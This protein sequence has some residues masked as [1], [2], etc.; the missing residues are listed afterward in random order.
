MLRNRHQWL[1]LFPLAGIL[2]GLY[3]FTYSGR[4]ESGDTLTLFNAT[5]SLVDYGDVLLDKS[6]AD[7]PPPPELPLSLYPLASVDVEP[8]QLILSAPLYWLASH[9]SHVGLVHAVWFFN[10]LVC[11]A[12]ALVFYVYAMQLGYRQGVAVLAAL[13]LGVGTIIW[14]YSKTFFREPLAGLFILLSALC[15][16]MLRARRYRSVVLFLVSAVLLTLALLTKEAVVFALPALLAVLF[17]SLPVPKRVWQ[18]AAAAVAAGVV[19]LLG[20]SVVGGSGALVP[21]YE[22]LAVLLRRTP[23]QVATMHQAFHSYVFSIG[24]S[25]WGT[26]PILLLGIPGLILFYRKQYY[27]Y[28]LVILLGLLGFAAGYAVLRGDHWFGGLSWPPR[29]LVPVVPL[30]MISILPALDQMLSSSRRAWWLL[31]SVFVGTWS[32]WIQ[33]TAVSVDWGTY[34]NLLPAEANGLLEWGGGLNV[35][36]YLRWIL[37][38]RVWGTI[39]LDFA[40]VRVNVPLWPLV[41]VIVIAVSGLWLIVFLRR[42]GGHGGKSSMADWGRAALFTSVVVILL[43]IGLVSINKDVIYSGGNAS[44]RSVLD[45]LASHM[46][47]DDVLLLADDEY[48]SFFLNS[49]KLPLPRVISLPDAPGEQPSETQ[50]ALVQSTNPDALLVKS[51]VP[52]IHNL[53][54]TRSRI[55]LLADFGSWHSWAV[56]PVERMMVMR[57]YPLQELTTDPPD[58]RVRL[59]EFSTVPAPD[60]FA[61][62]GPENLSDLRFGDAISLMGYSLPRGT[63]YRAGT[64]LPIS[65][66]WQADRA[67]EHNYTVAL[68]VADR[69]GKVVAQGADSQPAW[70][71]DPTSQWQPFIPVWDNRALRLPTDI[72]SG[73]YQI[74]LRLYQSDNSA[75][76]LPV[77]GDS[78]RDTSLAILPSEIQ[79]ES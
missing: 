24:G 22:T 61:F 70:G 9:I 27:R 60:P 11:T 72:T 23:Q 19:L 69:E 2:M 79:I 50:P 45:V 74:W 29:F 25:V 33:I 20:L 35:V 65:F 73:N 51:S 76:A 14:P 49:G 8:L 53:A 37:I 18:V 26:S 38:P 78:V 58:P 15:L 34:I 62:R 68:F 30:L 13:A 41:C 46:S 36:H 16:E 75:L 59:I 54:Q 40:W 5:A 47:T 1:I 42:Q 6:A 48:K 71:F 32:I 44:L 56:R 55:W 64:V 31:G 28:P 17:P 4:I 63:Q 7:T 43:V 12:T 21:L 77:M 57:Y 10:V 3:T 39:P 67:I 66:Y 52:L